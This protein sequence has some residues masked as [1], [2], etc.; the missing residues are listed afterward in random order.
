M[1]VLIALTQLPQASLGAVLL[2]CCGVI[3]VRSCG[4]AINDICDRKFDAQVTRTADRPLASG[5]ISL[6]WAFFLVGLSGLISLLSVV[7]IPFSAYPIVMLCA[8][9][10]VV[11]PLSKRF[12]PFPQIILGMAFASS[13]PC[14]YAFF[15]QPFDIRAQQFTLVIVAW[16]VAFDTSYALADWED[17]QKLSLQSLT[18]TL[19]Y[20]WSVRLSQFLLALAQLKMTELVMIPSSKVGLIPLGALAFSWLLAFHLMRIAELGRLEQRAF[21][22]HPYLGL[23]WVLALS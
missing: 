23:L 2:L 17:D 19:G 7:W 12:Y 13:I 11:Y 22:L 8:L 18:K 1:P 9:L 21:H 5:A 3:A 15:E 14:L 20:C 10:I 6:P 16:V 4:C